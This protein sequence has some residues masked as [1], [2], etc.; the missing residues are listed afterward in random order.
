MI[1]L[2]ERRRHKN[3][4]SFSLKNSSYGSNW[5]KRVT[6]PCSCYTFCI[7]KMSKTIDI[8]AFEPP[9]NIPVNLP[10][11]C[12]N[13]CNFGNNNV[14]TTIQ[15]NQFESPKTVAIPTFSG[16]NITDIRCSYAR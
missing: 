10:E 6:N 16:V 8:A 9:V 4:P 11:N 13:P 15:Q 7:K 14:I 2:K 1:S 12:K 3:V 5:N